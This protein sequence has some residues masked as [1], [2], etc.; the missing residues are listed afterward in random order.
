M[1]SQIH[2]AQQRLC[3][4]AGECEAQAAASRGVP[5]TSVSCVDKG[6]L[7]LLMNLLTCSKCFVISVA[8]TMSIIPWRSVR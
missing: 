5:L 7:M 4:G 8:R 1:E 3:Y 2:H 6:L